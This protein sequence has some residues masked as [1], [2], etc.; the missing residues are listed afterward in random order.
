[1]ISPRGRPDTTGQEHAEVPIPKKLAYANLQ[2]VGRYRRVI[3]RCSIVI[4]VAD[5]DARVVAERG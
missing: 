4:P 1:M 5:Y 2:V 3:S